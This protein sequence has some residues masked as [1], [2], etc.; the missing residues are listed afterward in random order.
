MKHLGLLGYPLSHSHS[1]AMINRLAKA[2]NWDCSYQ[3]YSVEPELLKKFVSDVHRLPISGFNVTIPHKRT[4][5]SFCD[6]FS[7]EVQAIRAVNT[8]CNHN[9]KLIA[10]NTDVFGFNYGLQQLTKDFTSIKKAVLLGAGGAAR[11]AAFCLAKMGCS[12]LIIASR[13]DHRKIEWQRDCVAIFSMANVSFCPL[14]QTELKKHLYDTNLVVQTTPAGM[15]PDEDETPP[16]PFELLRQDHL[17]YD[18]IYNPSKTKFLSQA[19]KQGVKIQNGLTMLAAQA[20]KSLE[21]WGFEV[22]VEEVVE[23]LKEVNKPKS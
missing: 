16:F 17:V 9:G 5:L 11:A 22:E 1:P 6:Q 23:S 18:L 8:I 15:F 2:K 20:A 19:E 7:P 12:E 14:D 21:I 10:H 4:M 3:P 13:T